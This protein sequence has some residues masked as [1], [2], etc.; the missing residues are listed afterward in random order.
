MY[1]LLEKSF[2]TY[3]YGYKA[4]FKSTIHTAEPYPRISKFTKLVNSKVIFK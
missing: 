4:Q 2:H 1:V 3:L